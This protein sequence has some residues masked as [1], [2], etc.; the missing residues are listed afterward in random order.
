LNEHSL[1]SPSDLV[2]LLSYREDELHIDEAVDDAIQLGFD[3]FSVL[4]ISK[5]TSIREY[6][7]SYF[8][9][10]FDQQYDTNI[11]LFSVFLLMLLF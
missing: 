6:Q 4:P 7:P 8:T 2:F 9:N 3:T 10:P 11:I 1:P 5:S